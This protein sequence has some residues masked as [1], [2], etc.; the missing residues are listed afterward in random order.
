[1]NLKRLTLIL[2]IVIV[3]LAS[4]NI[5]NTKK[6]LSLKTEVDT[7]AIHFK[8]KS[9]DEAIRVSKKKKLPVFIYFTADG[10]GP[11]VK[12]DKTV[13]PDSMVM[14][15]FN[16]NFICAKSHR[17]RLP[18]KDGFITKEEKELNKPI[19]EI[20]ELYQ[21]YGTPSF[22]VIDSE[23]NLLNKRI[24]FLDQKQL[25]Q[26]GKDAL[27]NDNNYTAIEKKINDGEY[28][29]ENVNAFLSSTSAPY[30]LTERISAAIFGTKREKVIENYFKTQDESKWS[31]DNNW[32]LI[33]RYIEDFDSK[34]IQYLLEH[35]E[36][37]QKKFGVIRVNSKVYRIL[38]QYSNK[39]GNINNLNYPIAEL[40]RKKIQLEDQNI[41]DLNLYD[42]KY[43]SIYTNYYYLFDYEINSASW[44]IY[45]KSIKE[46][47][48]IENKTIKTATN[49]MALIT[50]YRRE[51]KYYR[52]T[53]EKLEQ[54]LTEL[55]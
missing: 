14:N 15:F 53:Y 2:L 1:M 28:S 7:S 18:S 33:K 39:G 5:D 6:T 55:N 16:Q 23:G 3:S 20:M 40:I 17:K 49:W 46:G 48:S 13:F 31:S 26:F 21:V 45:L 43:N 51:N 22:V 19:D 25:L 32:Y 36:E 11:C 4:C 10:C 37:F 44:S 35:T 8:Y 9:L 38:A 47:A 34:Q 30:T 27:G 29:F 54:K 24:S 52:D 50:S 42:E 12:M 41:S